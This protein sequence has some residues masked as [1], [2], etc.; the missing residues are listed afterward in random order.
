MSLDNFEP[1]DASVNRFERMLNEQRNEFFDLHEI[2][3]VAE[4]YILSS[5]WR[6]VIACVDFGLS[7]HPQSPGLM[8]YKAQALVAQNRIHEASNLIEK[9]HEIDPFNPDVYMN[10]GGLCQRT[11]KDEE[12]MKHYSRALE[13]DEE[14]RPEVLSIKA[15]YW[16]NKGEYLSALP[17]IMELIELD[18]YD[19]QSLEMLLDIAQAEQIQ[20]Q[21][22]DVLK[23][24]AQ[25][26][27]GN[28]YLQ[29]YIGQLYFDVNDFANAQLFV[30]SSAVEHTPEL[31]FERAFMMGKIALAQV[32]IDDAKKWFH[33][34]REI[35]ETDEIL[36]ILS[37][38]ALI[39][40]NYYEAMRYAE[41]AYMI[42]R[43]EPQ[44]AL[45]LGQTH[46]YLGQNKEASRFFRQFSNL[47]SDTDPMHRVAASELIG[48]GHYAEGLH[49]YARYLDHAGTRSD[50]MD[51]LDIALT[52]SDFEIALEQAEAARKKYPK[53][54]KFIW[55]ASGAALIL[56]NQNY[57]MDLLS[58][59]TFKQE[60]YEQLLDFYPEIAD[61]SSLKKMITPWIKPS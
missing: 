1:S 56:G 16:Y 10:L 47:A 19:D 55:Y 25:S 15:S 46:R 54:R 58:K 36:R 2:E 24:F 52:C 26:E 35:E 50:Y 3:S 57:A 8:L 38:V 6:R 5:N 32:A 45:L 20:D 61:I 7:L 9:V 48:I 33:I 53:E 51:F 27:P 12:A 60:D 14:L 34:A 13:L 17:Y 23:R 59:N 28:Y 21:V 37:E 49:I 39:D 40:G 31:Q 22:I 11:G 41:K 18:S 4:H 29:L 43:E 30:G 42:N 44:N